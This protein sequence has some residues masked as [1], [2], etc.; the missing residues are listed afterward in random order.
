[1]DHM[2][3]I[4][5]KFPRDFSALGLKTRDGF[6]QTTLDALGAAAKAQAGG[7]PIFAG[8]PICQAPCSDEYGVALFTAE[9]VN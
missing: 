8:K 4:V 6:A 7:A 3:A 9:E 1:T 5:S 2:I